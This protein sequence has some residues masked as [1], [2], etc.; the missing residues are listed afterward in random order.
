MCLPFFN[1]D[2]YTRATCLIA[3]TVYFSHLNSRLHGID[4]KK[5]SQKI[6][7]RTSIRHMVRQA[8]HDEHCHPEFIEGAVCRGVMLKVGMTMLYVGADLCVCQMHSQSVNISSNL[9]SSSRE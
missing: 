6:A 8:H 9:S 5:D 1:N 7:A 2:A 4:K 3:P